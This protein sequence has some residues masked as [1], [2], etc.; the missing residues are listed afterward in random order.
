MTI[1][2]Q[3]RAIAKI[4]T[5][6][7]LLL[8]VASCG[9]D[10][11]KGLKFHIPKKCYDAEDYFPVYERAQAHALPCLFHTG[12]VWL[13]NPKPEERISSF[14]MDPIHIEGVAQIFP[15]L[16]LII[17]HLGVQNHL[18]AL[19]LV[20]ILPNIHADLSGTTPGWRANLSMEDWKRFLWFPHASK[21][22]LFGSDVHLAEIAE[23]AEIY[24]QICSAAGWDEDA[25]QALF[26]DN[27]ACLFGL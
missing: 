22:L 2:R 17:A 13:P 15:D 27:A 6:A 18:T 19:T 26:H 7:I 25:R 1:G 21:K 11:F 8:G 20:R 16:P 12:V 24:E 4:G 3:S 10:G 9:E 23:N 5:M 14:N